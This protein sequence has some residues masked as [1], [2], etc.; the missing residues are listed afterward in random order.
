MKLRVIVK[1]IKNQTIIPFSGIIFQEFIGSTIEVYPNHITFRTK[2]GV[3][4]DVIV[5]DDINI[6]FTINS[7][8][9]KSKKDGI[10]RV[11]N[12]I[13]VTHISH[14]YNLPF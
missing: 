1:E 11:A 12:Y 13:L 4:K 7:R 6:E 9:W 14:N 3:L 8:T 10:E 2:C 5:G